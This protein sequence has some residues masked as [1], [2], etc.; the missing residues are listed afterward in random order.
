RPAGSIPFGSPRSPRSSLRR[1]RSARRSSSRTT[2]GLPRRSRTGWSRSGAR[3]SLSRQ[4]RRLVAA[5][6]ASFAA[7]LVLAA[8]GESRVSIWFA[9]AALIGAAVAWLEGGPDSAKEI[10]L[11][12]TL[13]GAAAA[14]RVLFA[15][16]PGV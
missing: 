2:G 3:R 12:A 14:G 7:S 11:V 8:A 15:A 13:A 6:A 10:A 5:A 4:R 9:A 16:V 1:L